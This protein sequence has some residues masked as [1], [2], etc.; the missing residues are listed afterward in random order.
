MTG[1]ILKIIACVTMLIDHSAGVL[2]YNR[3]IDYSTYLLLRTIGRIAFPIFGFLVVEGYKHT[4]N[5]RKYQLRLLIVALLSELPYQMYSQVLFR[6]SGHNVI[7]LFLLSTLLF[8]GWEKSKGKIPESIGMIILTMISAVIAEKTG[9]DYGMFGLLYM[10]VIYW[11]KYRI[12]LGAGITISYSVL[13]ANNPYQLPCLFAII[14]LCFYN[15]KRGRKNRMI[16]Y[17]FYLIYPLQ[18]VLWLLML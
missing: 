18:Y 10:L 3:L 7:W 13:I 15:G 16:Q 17:G 12:L 8:E 5:I 14:P 11:G 2:Y 4:R 6:D 1:N 9:I